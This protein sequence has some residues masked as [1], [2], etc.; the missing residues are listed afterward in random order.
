MEHKSY[1]I[2]EFKAL[3]GSDGPGTFEA[4]VSV[5]GNVDHGG[6][7]VH[8]GAFKRSL[9]EW[10]AKGRSVPILWSHN[11]ETPPIGV[12]TEAVENHEGLRV[13][14]R[15]LVDDN[16]GSKAV[17]AAMKAGALNEF[18]FGYGAREFKHRVEEGGRKIRDLFD[19]D[20]FEVS[21]VFKGMNPATRLM[22][23]K[24]AEIP[25][26]KAEIERKIA[27]LEAEKA[28]LDHVQALDELEASGSSDTVTDGN[29]EQ[30]D[31]PDSNPDDSGE[32]NLARIMQL[33]IAKPM[34][35]E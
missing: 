16:P 25:D 26:R 19:V 30:H 28:A 5:F 21:P 35:L 4:I 8:R 18:S 17:H 27:E 14:G 22:G 7:M 11:P 31:N 12:V 34:H 29:E 1:A 32:E 20:L 6:D 3:N 13:K 10:K 23:V 9:A 15:L 2:T 33:R 24:S